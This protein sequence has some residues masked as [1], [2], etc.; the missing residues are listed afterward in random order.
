MKNVN[1]IWVMSLLLITLVQSYA[2]VPP[3]ITKI[4]KFDNKPPQISNV[5]ISAI[6]ERSA[7]IKWISDEIATSWIVVSDKYVC[8]S[9][10]ENA[11]LTINHE[12]IIDPSYCD[13]KC[14][15]TT[16]SHRHSKI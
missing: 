10:G 16:C 6:G 5:T 12:A 1:L 8:W 15:R 9:L 14:N 2:C 3:A 4:F 11:T 13:I 7:A